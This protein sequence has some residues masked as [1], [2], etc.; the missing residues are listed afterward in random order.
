MVLPHLQS[1]K[2]MA[3]SELYATTT[4]STNTQSSM[5]PRCQKYPR[6]LKNSKE[7]RSLAS[8]TSEQGTTTSTYWQRT[9]IKLGSKQTRDYSNGSLCHSDYATHRPPSLG[10]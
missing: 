3:H 9:R 5:L 4:N 7:S 6:S 2:K 1:R 10:C 8:S